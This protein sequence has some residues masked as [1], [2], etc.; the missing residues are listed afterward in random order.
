MRIGAIA[1]WT[2]LIGSFAAI[3]LDLSKAGYMVFTEPQKL[4]ANQVPQEFAKILEGNTKDCLTIPSQTKAVTVSQIRT[5][6]QLTN[7]DDINRVLGNAFCQT[8]DGK[9]YLTE[10]GQELTIKFNEILD[11]DFS[12]GAAP[13]ALQRRSSKNRMDTKKAK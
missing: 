3:A 1:T 4:I 5:L 11:Y 2:L 7:P 13:T 10:S 6:R 12:K 8:K 9:K